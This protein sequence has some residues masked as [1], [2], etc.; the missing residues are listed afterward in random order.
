MI[1]ALGIDPGVAITGFAVVSCDAGKYTLK[2]YGVIRTLERTPLPERL[3]LL[4]RDMNS[5][6]ERYESVDVAG[7]EELF[8]AKNVTTAFMVGQARGVILLALE[9]RGVRIR[10]F[11]PVEVK[12]LIVGN[13]QAKK[14]D[15]QRMVQLTFGLQKP[16]QPDDAADAVAIA[17]AACSA[18]N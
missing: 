14:A 10:E 1:T 4:Y 12:S 11:K 17:M 2:E 3:H 13:G 6:L 15:V 8:F 5:V 18:I 7:V 9:G 16:P